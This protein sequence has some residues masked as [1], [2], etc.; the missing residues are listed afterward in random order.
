[1]GMVSSGGTNSQAPGFSYTQKKSPCESHPGTRSG[2]MF[3][4]GVPGAEP[5]ASQSAQPSGTT[6]SPLS[7]NWSSRGELAPMFGN[8]LILKAISPCDFPLASTAA[9]EQ[10]PGLYLLAP[11]GGGHSGNHTARPRQLHF[12]R[13]PRRRAGPVARLPIEKAL[14]LS[15][16]KSPDDGAPI[17]TPPLQCEKYGR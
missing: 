8:C 11:S 12:T 1:M 14:S 13:S 16:W 7:S 9:G 15:S 6:N 2:R 4:Y 17:L 3:G 5:T 10:S